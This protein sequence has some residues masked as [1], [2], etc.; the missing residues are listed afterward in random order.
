[1]IRKAAMKGWERQNARGDVTPA[2]EKYPT[3]DPGW[4]NNNNIHR[5]P[6]KDLKNLIIQGIKDATPKL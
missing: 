1:M 5:T 2:E 4:N 6:M 3:R